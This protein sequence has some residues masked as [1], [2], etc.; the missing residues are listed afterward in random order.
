M[1]F[2]PDA[3]LDVKPTELENFGIELL[4]KDGN[5]PEMLLLVTTMKMPLNEANEIYKRLVDSRDIQTEMMKLPQ[6]TRDRVWAV[7]KV[8]LKDSLLVP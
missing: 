7:V 3:P 4:R 2:D 8:A 6:K 5:I 1:G